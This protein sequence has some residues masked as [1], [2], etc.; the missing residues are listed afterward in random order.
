MIRRRTFRSAAGITEEFLAGTAA[1]GPG[2]RAEAETL[3]AEYRAAL[4]AAE[5]APEGTLLL[6]FHL[7]DPVNQYP[8]LVP[9][10][11][12]FDL[13]VSVIGQPPADGSRIALESWIWR[14]APRHYEARF[15]QVKETA[16]GNSY[17]Q[18][19]AEFAAVDG[20]VRACGGSV[21]ANLQ[22]TWLYCRD[23]D[24]DY[25]GLVAARNDFFNSCALRAD[26]H[27]IASTGIGGESPDPARRV[28]MD[29]LLWFGLADGQ[30]HYLS[31]PD[32]LS[33]TALYGVAFERGS[34]IVFG[35]RAH[36]YISGTASI[37]RDGRVMHPGNVRAQTGRMIEN[38]EA[39]LESGGSSLA[40]IRQAT[41]YLRDGADAGIVREELRRRGLPE[42]LPTVMVTGRVCR[43]AWLVEMEAIAISPSGDDRFLPLA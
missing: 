32:N 37:D 21:P 14:T 12:D 31:A 25:A 26:T 4:D 22:R 6:R 35:D 28:R 9:L 17:K 33:P 29:S 40:E 39:L 2:F 11:A 18:T 43:P 1:P 36:Y 8:Q 3:L 24:N 30:V 15:F 19:A 34:R 42:D 38:V 41:V 5:I 7:S 13:P 16:E 23:V 27:F 20:E 10:V